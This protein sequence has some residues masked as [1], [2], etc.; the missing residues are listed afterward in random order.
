[1]IVYV[2][3][4]FLLELAYLQERCDSCQEILE[5]AKTGAITLLLPAFS[6]A[7]ARATQ[8]RRLSERREFQESLK[9]HIREI[10]RS[11]TFRGLDQQTTDIVRAF[12]SGGEE[13]R[14]RLESAIQSINELPLT[15]DV[16]VSA[17][18][19]EPDLSPQDALVLA[20]ITEDAAAQTGPKCFISQDASAFRSPAALSVLT[21]LE[22]KVLY[23]FTDA[24]AYIK[25]ALRPP[26]QPS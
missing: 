4:N 17:R 14:E 24:V 26:A 23:N 20:S 12:V 13:T 16:V 1:V 2:E 11:E 3:T 15:R 25:N 7:E 22:C 19:H 5:L 6:A 8:H 9:K 21:A 18:R 10:S